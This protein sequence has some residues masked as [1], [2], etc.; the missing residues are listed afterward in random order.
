MRKSSLLLFGTAFVSSLSGCMSVIFPAHSNSHELKD[1]HVVVHLLSTQYADRLVQISDLHGKTQNATT[2]EARAALAWH[3]G[4]P[5]LTPAEAAV[6]DAYTLYRKRESLRAAALPAFAAAL[7]G[8]A[9][10]AVVRAGLDFVKGQLAAEA[11]LYEAQFGLRI[12][13]DRFWTVK[14][15]EPTQV[16]PTYWGFEVVRTIKGHDRDDPAFRLICGM[17]YSADCAFFSVFPISLRDT[18]AKAKVLSDEAWSYYALA[19]KPFMHGGHEIDVDVDVEM[20]AIW[21]DDKG[22]SHVE[23][24]CAF[25]MPFGAYDLDTCP[26]K[27]FLDKTSGEAEQ[28]FGWYP[29]IPRSYSPNSK[30]ADGV[31]TFWLKVQVTER[32]RTNVKRELERGAKLVADNEDK[33]IDRVVS[34]VKQK[35]GP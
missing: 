31:G 35:V 22:A 23:S 34:A 19:W 17:S 16:A 26:T 20:T 5:E 33:I 13:G 9:A 3:Q 4:A 2:D 15:N 14:P 8:P 27:V 30:T 24:V 32:D 10:G 18:N 12:A 25:D 1:E 6:K 29:G 7:V 28:V 21:R 11:Q